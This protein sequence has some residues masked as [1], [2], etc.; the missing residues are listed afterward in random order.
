MN[1][2]RPLVAALFCLLVLF[3]LA[4]GQDSARPS[5]LDNAEFG[6]I[7]DLKGLHRVIVATDDLEVRDVI[8]DELAKY[9]QLK[10]VG[11]S[12]DA[13]F[14]ISFSGDYRRRGEA[15]SATKTKF[16]KSEMKAYMRVADVGG[17]PRFRIVWHTN[18]TGKDVP[19]RA[20]RQFVAEFK[21]M[22]E[23]KADVK[24]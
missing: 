15:F 7:S 23:E 5:I 2:R 16:Y 14:V 10:V 21:K 4:Y 19:A 1:I 17:K 11:R 9:D 20:A 12:E 13:E 3:K 24:K 6:T 8:V 18:L 22:N